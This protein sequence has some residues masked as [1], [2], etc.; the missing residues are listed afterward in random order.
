MAR[1]WY[2][3]AIYHYATVPAMGNSRSSVFASE[4]G[5]G[6]GGDPSSTT[7]CLLSWN[8]DGLD[9]KHTVERAQAVCQLIES[10]K[11]DVVYL[12][13]IVSQTW[14]A[15][16]ERLKS[17][18]L[19]YRDEVSFHYYHILMVRKG[20]AVSVEGDLEVMRFP[21]SRQGRHLLQLPVKFCEIDIQL[22]TSHLESL[23]HNAAERK[24]QLRMTF[25][26]MGELL[27]ESKL[28]IFAGDTNLMDK[29]VTIVGIPENIVDVWE[30]CGSDIKQKF[31]WD[32]SEPRFRLDR[33]YFSATPDSKLQARKFVLVGDDLLAQYGVYPSDHLGMWVE[34]SLVT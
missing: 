25:A 28:G 30:A 4:K 8:I 16:T 20:S 9:R 31:T 27:L 12:Q 32:S 21:Q 13:E 26:L 1:Y 2:R 5:L 24:N 3:I 18:Y 15:I 11:P 22:M 29:E 33:A 19:F 14:D 7:L 6:T 10:H 17:S 23:N 34:F